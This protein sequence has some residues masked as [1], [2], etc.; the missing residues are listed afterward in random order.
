MTRRVKLM[1][2]THARE[3]K[4]FAGT[5]GPWPPEL[6]PWLGIIFA[7]Q[8]VPVTQVLLRHSDYRDEVRLH[9]GQKI[10]LSS[11]PLDETAWPLMPEQLRLLSP[12]H[13]WVQRERVR[14]HSQY[15]FSHWPLSGWDTNWELLF[16]DTG[17]G[18]C[19]LTYRMPAL[20]FR[21]RVKAK[22]HS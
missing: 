15:G 18:Y 14:W 8:S 13:C 17:T 7:A 10:R 16:N 5:L 3:Y 20:R 12:C 2:R 1:M 4:R 9:C 21:W 6:A 22:G 19:W 11:L